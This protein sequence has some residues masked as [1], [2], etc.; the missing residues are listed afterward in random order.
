MPGD[1]YQLEIRLTLLRVGENG[2]P[3]HS[4][5]FEMNDNQR[6]GEM[7]FPQVLEVMSNIHT[8]VASIGAVAAG[9][10]PGE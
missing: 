1:K 7:T 2:Y 8:A 6:L 5:R 3:T 4:D 10:T 9:Q